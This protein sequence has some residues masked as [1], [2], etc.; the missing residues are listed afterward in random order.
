MTT[1]IGQNLGAG[2]EDRAMEAFIKASRATI[3]IGIFSSIAI[4]F[5]NEVMLSI[6]IESE[7]SQKVVGQALEY[8]TYSALIVPLM[9]MYNVFTGL[10]QGSGHTKYAMKMEVGRLWFV[11]IPMILIFNRFTDLGS[12]G[13]WISMTTSNLIICIYAYVIYLRGYW[14]ET[15]ISS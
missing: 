8:L 12:T 5:N 3:S 6:F 1:I 14:R 13:I 2:K 10:F 11:R 4:L 9:G 15:V 7:T